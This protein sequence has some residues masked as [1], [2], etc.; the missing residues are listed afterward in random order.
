MR[1]RNGKKTFIR[2]AVFLLGLY[3]AQFSRAQGPLPARSPVPGRN[4]KVGAYDNYPK[5][6][7]GEHGE[8]D[9]LFPRLLRY[10]AEQEGWDLEFVFG[11]WPECLERLKAGEIDIMVDVALSEERAR[12]Y[13][14]SRETVFINWGTVYAGPELN[15]GSLFDLEGRKVAVMKGSIHTEGENGI[16]QLCDKFDIKCEFMEAENYEKVFELLDQGQADAGVVNRIYGTLLE[17]R[18]R[19]RKTPIVFDPA[20]LKFAFPKGAALSRHLAQKIDAHIGMLKSDP[21]SAYYRIIDSY[22]QGIDFKQVNVER[23][24]NI[25]LT[26]DE[27]TWLRNHRTIRVG[28]DPDCAP[29]SFVDANG[30]PLG[31]AVDFLELLG[32]GLGLNVKMATGLS[33]ARILES[34]REKSTDVAATASDSPSRGEYLDFTRKY[35]PAPLALVTRTDAVGF[36]SLSDLD[37]KTVALIK[38]YAVADGFGALHPSAGQYLVDTPLEGLKAV[39]TGKADVHV[40]I[41]GVSAYLIRQHGIANLKVA[42]FYDGRDDGQ[43]FGVRRDW[44]EL[45]SILDKALQAIPQKEKDAIFNA[46]VPVQPAP[47]SPDAGAAPVVLTAE[48]EAWIRAHPVIRLGIDPEFAPF[49]YFASDGTYSG[50]ASDY[51]RIVSRRTGLNM[52]VVPALSWEEA[53]AAARR[54]EIDVLPAIGITRARASFLLYSDPHS[55]FQRVIIVRTDTP[56]LAGIE[57][58]SGWKVAVQKDSSH[59]GY[60]AE[61]TEIAPI[62]Y[63]KLQEA[64]VAVADGRADAFVGNVA[65]ATYWIRKLNLANLKVAASI[66]EAQGLHFGVRRDWPELVG[67]INKGLASITPAEESEIHRRWVSVEYTPGLQPSVVRKYATRVGFVVLLILLASFAWSYRLKQEIRQRRKF[68]AELQE[69]RAELETRVRARTAELAEAN[70]NLMDEVTERKETEVE[71][72]RYRE[73]LEELVRER[74]SQLEAAKARAESADRLKSAFLATMSHELRTPLNSII[75]FTGIL[76][77]EL[78]GSLNEEQKKQLGMIQ[79]SSRHLLELINDV[80]DISKIEAGQLELVSEEFDARESVRRVLAAVSPLAAAKNLELKTRLAAGLGEVRGDRRRFEQ[81]LLNLVNNSIKFT[82]RGAVEVAVELRSGE[83]EVKVSDTGI[84]I[85][86]EDMG[87]LF[88][89]FQ[90]LDTGLDRKVEGTGLGLSICKKLVEKMGGRI[91]VESEWGSGSVFSFRI[92][93]QEA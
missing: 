63:D 62:L 69:A 4:I 9:G 68:E 6:Y 21:D 38:G 28:I 39:S 1:P 89:T 26:L 82:D 23:I 29:Y 47:A 86:K 54:S 66:P 59:H 42:A 58:I 51:V 24:R 71:L 3:P 37:G 61:N 84:G 70:L 8:A 35:I 43:R 60:L 53:V 27:L 91:T 34:I 7:A 18:Y 85:R 41:L 74:T 65:S 25:D 48:E 92:P 77:Q 67:I 88:R 90:Q 75:G 20:R 15:L 36:T 10:V 73:H 30:R 5:V 56:F 31:I 19:V 57:D 81:V 44:P 64:L 2:V 22:L 33:R 49:E 11:S 55:K 12:E 32:K 40:G 45:V 13:D 93:A 76:L 52:K 79:G 46:W 87:K 14:F 50:I 16:R 80:L 83:L 17:E 78:P 72:K